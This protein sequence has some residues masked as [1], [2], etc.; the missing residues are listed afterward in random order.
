MRILLVGNPNSGKSSLFHALTGMHAQIA[1]HAGVTIEKQETDY[2]LPDGRVIELVDLPGLYS[3]TPYSEEEQLTLDLLSSGALLFVLDASQLRRNLY[4]LL[5]LID[6]GYKPLVALTQIDLAH[7]LGMSIDAQSLAQRLA[8]TVI[9]VSAK[10]GE[11]LQELELN[12]PLSTGWKGVGGEVSAEGD[13]AAIYT[14]IDAL[15]D[16]VTETK[17]VRRFDWDSIFLHPILGSVSMLFIFGALFA[18]LFGVGKPI[19]DYLEATFDVFGGQLLLMFE[20]YPLIGSLAVDG[21]IAG[22]GTLVAFVPLIGLLFLLLG[23]L[24][25]SGYLARATF[26]LD[27]MMSKAGLSGRAFVPLMSGYACAIPAIMSTRVI[28]SKHGR[29]IAMLV[30]PFLS[31]SARLPLYALLTAAFFSPWVGASVMLGL[32]VLGLLM[33]LCFGYLLKRFWFHAVADELI[34]ELPSYRVPRVWLLAQS[35]GRQV[36]SFLKQAGTLILC[37]SIL[38]WALFHFPRGAEIENSYAGLLGKLLEPVIAPLGFDWKIGI[39]LLAS[40]SAR[41]VMVSTLGII[42]GADKDWV[43]SYSPLQALSLLV[44]FALAMQ[45]TSTLVVMRRETGTWR[46]PLL[47]LGSMTFVAWLASFLVF[48]AGSALGY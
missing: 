34:L 30:I 47:Q 15:I 26:L 25:Q 37:M 39:G 11:G 19:A 31:C 16:G 17:P 4:L 23:I 14:R 29:L 13:P 9:P 36:A 24:E 32:Y 3:L 12:F 2:T 20:G 40:F 42:H 6:A 10:T 43:L 33:A 38:M 5:E 44:F 41:E 7:E 22:V 8:L 35:V 46:W 28:R 45:C 21:I 48:Q 27:R 18:I 1:N